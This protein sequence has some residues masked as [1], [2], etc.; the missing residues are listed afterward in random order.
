MGGGGD[1]GGKRRG[2]RGERPRKRG[3]EQ[4]DEENRKR[5]RGRARE[6]GKVTT[7]GPRSRT[8]QHLPRSQDASP[9]HVAPTDSSSSRSSRSS[10][11]GPHGPAAPS[12]PLR[13][14]EGGTAGAAPR[15]SRAARTT[16][17]PCSGQGAPERIGPTLRAQRVP[18]WGRS[19][20]GTMIVASG[21]PCIQ[22]AGR[23]PPTSEGPC[24][25]ARSLWQTTCPGT[26]EGTWA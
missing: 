13:R 17:G 3:G 2:R 15:A 19:Q 9:N 14:P 7:T 22:G 23:C 4:G 24:C 12:Q 26:G 21:P 20:G 25:R 18:C 8:S 6:R 11:P 16:A 1:Q 10:G 5:T